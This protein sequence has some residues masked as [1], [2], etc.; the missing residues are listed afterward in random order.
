MLAWFSSKIV[1]FGRAGRWASVR[2]QH[3]AKEPACVACG[4][5]KDVQV[6]HIVPVHVD[7]D[8]ELREDNLITLCGDP[9]HLVHG[10]LLNWKRANPHVREDAEGY[11]RRLREFG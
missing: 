3:L 7:P 1:E 6:H 4:R 11:F 5:T 10:H 2:R 8:G 9:C